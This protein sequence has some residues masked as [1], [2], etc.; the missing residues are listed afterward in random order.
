MEKSR[1]AIL[2]PR[3]MYFLDSLPISL[4]V[5]FFFFFIFETISLKLKLLKYFIIKS[6]KIV[7]VFVNIFDF[8][9][10]IKKLIIN[11]KNL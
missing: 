7:Y 3:R 1:I 11:R 10:K 2:T 4:F 8:F 5:V 9:E 6:A